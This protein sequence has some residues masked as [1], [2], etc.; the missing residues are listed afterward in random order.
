MGSGAA[1][2]DAG[3]ESACSSDAEDRGEDRMTTSSGS[4]AVGGGLTAENIDA[5]GVGAVDVGA[6]IADVA[7]G[8]V[9]GEI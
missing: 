4:T 3:G 7:A 2:D 1:N 8:C 9:A 6:A 5:W